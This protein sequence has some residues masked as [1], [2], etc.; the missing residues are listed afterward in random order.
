MLAERARV[1]AT[2]W[3][4]HV[5][6]GCMRLGITPNL[7]TLVSFAAVAGVGGV[8]ALGHFRLAGVLLLLTAWFDAVDGTLARMSGRVSP[9]GAFL[10]ATLDRYAEIFLYLGLLVY[11]TRYFDTYAIYLIYFTIVGSLL[12]SYTRAKAESVGIPVREGFLTRFERMAIL[13]LGLLFDRTEF[14]LWLLAPLTHI[15][16]VQR[17]VVVWMRSREDTR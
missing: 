7:L 6:R 15:T 17:M 11:Y 9:F 4:H 2:W 5:A 12:I 8:I 1:W 14:A 13:V 16:A 3:L 10:D